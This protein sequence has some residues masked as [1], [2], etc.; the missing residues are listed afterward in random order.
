MFE[1]F[2]RKNKARQKLKANQ[3]IVDNVM[4]FI[5]TEKE[6]N[7]KILET[8]GAGSQTAKIKIDFIRVLYQKI[9]A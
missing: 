2:K 1:K 5:E 3:K 4:K 7:M 9:N 8:R 6:T